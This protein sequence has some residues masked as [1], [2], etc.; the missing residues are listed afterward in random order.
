MTPNNDGAAGGVVKGP[1]NNGAAGRGGSKGR[2]AR[3]REGGVVE[4][5]S[6][7][8]DLIWY[9]VGTLPFYVVSVI[10]RQVCR[11]ITCQKMSRDHKTSLLCDKFCRLTSQAVVNSFT[12]DWT[13]C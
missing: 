5:I 7:K 2:A 10:T 6:I 11:V 9:N 8:L 12:C 3:R 1:N 13:C 4:V